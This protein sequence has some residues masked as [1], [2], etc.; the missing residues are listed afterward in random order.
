MRI[1]EV[2]VPQQGALA[3]EVPECPP[4]PIQAD[5]SQDRRVFVPY[6]AQ[7]HDQLPQC[8]PGP[9]A[10]VPDRIPGHVQL[11][12]EQATLMLRVRPDLPERGRELA[13]T[14]RDQHPGSRDLFK[15]R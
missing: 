13:A 11:K 5:L 14:I 7:L 6:A 8:S 15:Q 2:P 9:G 12:V 1:P 3:G 4:P 10:R